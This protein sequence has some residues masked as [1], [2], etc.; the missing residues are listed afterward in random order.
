[1]DERDQGG[2]ERRHAEERVRRRRQLHQNVPRYQSSSA[3]PTDA[4]AAAPSARKAPNGSAYFMPPRRVT[5]SRMPM[6]VPANDARINVSSPSFHPRNAPI[7][8][9]IFTSP[10]PRPSSWRTR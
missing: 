4:A 3:G 1:D 8:A 2:H 7:I 10:M 6:I 9:S 5:I